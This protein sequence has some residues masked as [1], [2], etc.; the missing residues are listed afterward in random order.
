LTLEFLPGDRVFPGDPPETDVAI[1]YRQYKVTEVLNNTT[2]TIAIGYVELDLA[3]YGGR[4]H[5]TR[6]QDYVDPEVGVSPAD[7]SL[8]TMGRRRLESVS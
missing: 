8:Q 3:K 5:I 4:W 1:L 2:R 7:Q 6:W